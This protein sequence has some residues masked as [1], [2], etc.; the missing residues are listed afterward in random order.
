MSLWCLKTICSFICSGFASRCLYALDPELIFVEYLVNGISNLYYFRD[1]RGDHY[2]LETDEGKQVELTNEMKEIYRDGTLYTV[3][4]KSYIGLLKAAFA[5]CQ[6][7]Q[8]A[9]NEAEVTHKSLINLVSDYH[10]YVCDWD[11]CVVYEKAIPMFKVS[12]APVAS[13]GISS[14]TFKAHGLI[15]DKEFDN[16][17]TQ[18]FQL[19]NQIH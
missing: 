15:G 8:P 13:F 11:E 2:L 7:I 16:S 10:G 14:I 5:E 12:W 18:S 9:I 1:D 3:E 17:L 19:K 6:E 4:S